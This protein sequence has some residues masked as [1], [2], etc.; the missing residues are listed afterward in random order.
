[1][2]EKIIS[3]DYGGGIQIRE[4]RHPRSAEPTTKEYGMNSYIAIE[5]AQQALEI[6]II[7]KD[8]IMICSY[9]L[10]TLYSFI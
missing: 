2:Q 1:M 4:L 6:Y 5:I 3:K 9:N 10:Y 8:V 7:R